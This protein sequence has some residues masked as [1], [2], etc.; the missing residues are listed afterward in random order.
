METKLAIPFNVEQ[1]EEQNSQGLTPYVNLSQ[2]GEA[3]TKPAEPE[4]QDL[5]V[6]TGLDESGKLFIKYVGKSFS[7]Q[8]R[9]AILDFLPR[10][11]G[12]VSP[13]VGGPILNE[14]HLFIHLKAE[15]LMESEDQDIANVV[16]M[17]RPKKLKSADQIKFE[18]DYSEWSSACSVRKNK[19]RE[20]KA[21]LKVLRD[22]MQIAMHQYE[23]D[24][25][26]Q[27][28]IVS[29]LEAEPIPE[30]PAKPSEF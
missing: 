23:I 3:Q 30:R 26:E 4:V 6:D 5:F 10:L 14:N 1:F 13:H 17:G 27:K 12:M 2:L 22:E 9:D 20:A 8:Q 19:I 15:R 18:K 21:R 28:L 29:N 16:T 25:R 24:I 11:Y 7:D